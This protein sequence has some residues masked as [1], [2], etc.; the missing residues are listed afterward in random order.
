M[1]CEATYIGRWSGNTYTCTQKGHHLHHKGY[2]SDGDG[3]VM[4]WPNSDQFCAN[5]IAGVNDICKRPPKHK[6]LCRIQ[7]FHRTISFR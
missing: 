7:V 3:D 6:G 5:T 2:D 4:E 1:K